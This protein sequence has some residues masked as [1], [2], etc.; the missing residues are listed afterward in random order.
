MISINQSI[1]TSL[2]N[3]KKQLSDDAVNL[4]RNFILSQLNKTG[5]FYD[6]A[7]ESD[8]YYSVFGYTLSYVFD[9]KVDVK[10]NI[11]F[12]NNW[13]KNNKVDFVHATSLL[14]CYYLLEAINY[15]QQFK[16]IANKASNFKVFQ[17]FVSYFIAQKIRKKHKDLLLTVSKYK[18]E[19]NGFNHLEENAKVASPYANFLAFGLLEDLQFAKNW[20]NEISKSCYNLMLENGAFVNNPK[21]K[22]GISSTTAA[23]IILL[24]S[25]KHDVLDSINWLKSMIGKSGGFYAG[26]NVPICDVLSTATSLFALNLIDHIEPEINNK[27]IE[28][29]N[30]HWDESGGFFGSVADQI[31]DVEYTFYGLLTIGQMGD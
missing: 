22:Q 6:R 19:D 3:A 2:L 14:R 29:I 20:R 21:S 18:S 26:E 23:G 4:I 8:P 30:L 31:P 15:T 24:K 10:T 17:S 27:A 5:G 12:L 7:N 13:R 1:L 16:T 28:F 11:Q 25:V 9:I